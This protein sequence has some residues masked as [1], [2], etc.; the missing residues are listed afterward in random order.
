MKVFFSQWVGSKRA[1]LKG[2]GYTSLYI[3][4]VV[5][6]YFGTRLSVGLFAGPTPF[7]FEYVL[8][9]STVSALLTSYM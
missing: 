6:F 3:I 8:G 2:V 5:K 7:E 9:K 1:A 4:F